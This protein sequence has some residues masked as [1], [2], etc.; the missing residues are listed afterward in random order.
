MCIWNMAADTFGFD[1]THITSVV[2]T[3]STITRFLQAKGSMG[4]SACKGMGKTFLLKAKRMIMMNDQSYMFLPQNQLVDTPGPVILNRNQIKFLS[5]YSNWVSIWTFCISAYILSQPD[6]SVIIKEDVT[7]TDLDPQIREIL[8]THNEGVYHVLNRILSK[9]TVRF[10]RAVIESSA[11]LFPILQ[12]INRQIVL[13]VDKLEEPFNRGYYKVGGSTNSAEGKYNSSIWAYAQL[14]FAE[15][16][17]LLYSGRHHIK[18]F[19][20]IRQEALYGAEAISVEYPKF[21]KEMMVPLAYTHEDL[22]RMFAKYVMAEKDENLYDCSKK[23]SDPCMALCGINSVE[24]RSGST[25]TLW[26]YIYRHS[27]GRPR[28]IMEI[29]SAL[30]NNIMDKASNVSDNSERVCRHWINQI[31]TRI[32]KEY[33]HVLEPFMGFEDNLEFAQ[34]IER[35]ITQLPTNVF[36]LETMMAY[37]HRSN[38]KSGQ[39]ECLECSEPHF[40]STLYNIG[41]LGCIYESQSEL[42]YKNSIKHIGDSIFSIASQTLPKGVLYYAHPGLSNMI[43]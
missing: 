32:C 33:L 43:Q 24:H 6:F 2:Y 13:F 34:E 37:C 30:Y 10:L 8:S 5:S 35:F 22:Y 40:F 1:D 38:K 11:L 9:K 7:I 12:R 25:E 3:N 19:Y 36:T 26:A 17:Y 4:I 21:C 42:G 23:Q 28:D 16:V 29:S 14:S 39:C 15:A 20:S 18:V 31:S 41:L 27:L